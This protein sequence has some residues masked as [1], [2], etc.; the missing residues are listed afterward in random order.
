M[1]NLTIFFILISICFINALQAQKGGKYIRLGIGSGLVH[2]NHTLTAFDSEFSSRSKISQGLDVFSSFEYYLKENNSLELG[3]LVS[4]DKLESSVFE[5]E[6]PSNFELMNTITGS[7]K[8][9]R[10][11]LYAGYGYERRFAS[12]NLIKIGLNLGVPFFLNSRDDINIYEFIE[13]ENFAINA[14]NTLTK[15]DNDF[16]LIINPYLSYSRILGV[17]ENKLSLYLGYSQAINE[18]YNANSQLNLEIGG[19]LNTSLDFRYQAVDFGIS[20]SIKLK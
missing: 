4:I 19:V 8:I 2:D 9:I 18:L 10:G 1:K 17:K 16:N 5:I 12:K 7:D 20:Y 11:L 6:N 3:M 13:K 14:E 15:I